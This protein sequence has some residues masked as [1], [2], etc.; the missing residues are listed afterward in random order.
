MRHGAEG[1]LGGV[2]ERREGKLSSDWKIKK[3]KENSFHKVFVKNW[4]KKLFSYH[5]FIRLL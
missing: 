5:L 2:K 4:K 1:C 3:G